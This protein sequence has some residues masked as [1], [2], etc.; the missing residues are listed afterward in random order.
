MRVTWAQNDILMKLKKKRLDVILSV[1][2]AIRSTPETCLISAVY[3]R[4]TISQKYYVLR[5]IVACCVSF[6]SSFLVI[7]KTL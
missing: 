4:Q 1:H 5:R 7:G 2:Y 3:L 6:P